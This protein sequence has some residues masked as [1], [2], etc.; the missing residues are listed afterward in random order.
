[1]WCDAS[2]AANILEGNKQ[3][4]PQ[5]NP[6]GCCPAADNPHLAVVGQELLLEGLCIG[7]DGLELG[8]SVLWQ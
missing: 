1:M 6:P 3:Y 2:M 8:V 7:S 5:T 4:L